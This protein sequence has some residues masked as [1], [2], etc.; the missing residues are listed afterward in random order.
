MKRFLF[1]LLLV[2]DRL[3]LW[4]ENMTNSYYNATGN[5]ASATLGRAANIRAEFDA[6]EV[7]FDLVESTKSTFDGGITLH[8]GMTVGRGASNVVSNTAMGISALAANLAGGTQNTAF[9]WKSLEANTSGDNNVAIGYA[10]G[11]NQTSGSDNVAVGKSAHNLNNGS[12]NVAVGSGAMGSATG[13]S[14]TV[15]IGN[16]TLNATTGLYNTAIGSSAGTAIVAGT[17]NTAV[18]YSAL[19]SNVS[20]SF[21]TAI[22]DNAIWQTTASN[23]TALGYAAGSNITSGANNVAIGYLA[24]ASSASV[25]NEITLGNS[26]HSTL[27]CQVTSITSLSDERDKTAISDLSF[28]LD[29]IASLRPVAFTWNT[30]DGAKVGVRSS[31][32]LAQDLK[33]AQENAGAAEVLRLVYEENPEKLEANYGHLMP[34]LVKAIQELKAEVDSLRLQLNG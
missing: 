25:S 7:G 22:G 6:I 31:G 29:F 33:A 1:W 32:F 26:G 5:P 23:N 24:Q 27:R 4:I 20:G 8:S 2:L 34:V 28:G 30:R 9:G 21:N 10:A 17:D 19:S 16:L 14:Y 13:C 12:S 3:S 11:Q 18:G 15:A